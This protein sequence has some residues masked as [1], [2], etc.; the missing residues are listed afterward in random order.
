MTPEEAIQQLEFDRAMI[1]FDSL[2]GEEITL[3]MLKLINKENYLIYVAD[4]IAIEALKEAQQYRE[5][6]TV[7]ECRKAVEKQKPEKP[8]IYT[9]TIQTISSSF[10][11]DVY[12]CSRCGQF[13]GN[14]DDELP[15]YCNCCGQRID[16]DLEGMENE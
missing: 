7:E 1:L 9:D 16:E 5:I 11:R 6:G 12:L 4:G 13:I 15:R 3:E 2:T 10:N 14:I 8:E